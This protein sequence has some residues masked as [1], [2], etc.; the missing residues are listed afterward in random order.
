MVKL[1]LLSLVSVPSLLNVPLL[2]SVP[3]LAISPLALLVRELW[4]VMSPA[5]II[6]PSLIRTAQLKNSK[7]SPIWSIPPLKFSNRFSFCM[8]FMEPGSFGEA[9]KVMRPSF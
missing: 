7:P 8:D 5:L 1:P 9:S 2:V 6:V 3:A 4:F